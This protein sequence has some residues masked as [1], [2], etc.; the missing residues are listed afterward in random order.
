MSGDAPRYSA[1]SPQPAALVG[2]TCATLVPQ[3]QRPPTFRQNQSYARAVAAAGGL[4]V[5]LPLLDDAAALRALYDRLDGLLLPGGG[6]VNPARYGQP[7]RPECHVEG[8]DDCRD[9]VELTLARWALADGKPLLGICRGQQALAVAAGG[10]LYQDIP[11]QLDGALPHEHADARTAL[12]HPIRV[13]PTSR[14]AAVLGA[15]ALDVNSIHHQAVARL[16]DGWRPVAWAPDG[17]VEGIEH[18]AHPFALAV[19]FH[20]EE[21]VPAHAPSVRLFAAFVAACQQKPPF[22]DREGGLGG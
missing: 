18:P 10:A 9:H 20:P 17:V 21:L 14:L 8:V 15:A 1:P 13:E 5:L 22:P 3:G 4:P 16:A 6:D 2:I 11:T 12:V 19:Q 7:A